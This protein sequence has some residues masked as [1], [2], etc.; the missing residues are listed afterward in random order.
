MY[1]KN[2]IFLSRKLACL[3]K[4]FYCANILLVFSLNISF[5]YRQIKLPH[6]SCFPQISKELRY[7]EYFPYF[8]R[9]YNMLTIVPFLAKHIFI[10][11]LRIFSFYI[12]KFLTR[13]FSF[14]VASHLFQD[15]ILSAWMGS[16]I[17]CW[18]QFSIGKPSKERYSGKKEA[19][20]FLFFWRQ[21]LQHFI[22]I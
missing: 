2:I 10:W 22:I 18:Q 17:K 1:K 5:C 20:S 9:E 15:W 16:V 3:L 11:L 21:A 4:M 8:Y 6:W 19:C 12:K 13:I 14:F 7:Q